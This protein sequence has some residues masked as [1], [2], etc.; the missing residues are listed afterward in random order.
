M[1]QATETNTNGV[2]GHIGSTIPIAPRIKKMNP[3]VVSKIVLICKESPSPYQELNVVQFYNTFWDAQEM[4]SKD[5][6][7]ASFGF[8]SGIVNLLQ[9]A[10]CP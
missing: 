5:F 9:N 10:W 8:T 2:V 3:R 6:Q 1:K 7:L 4:E